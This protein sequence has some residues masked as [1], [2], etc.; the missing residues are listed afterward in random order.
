MLKNKFRIITLLA[1]IILSLM[2]PIVRAENEITDQSD[3]SEEISVISA[4]SS[5]NQD[6]DAKPTTT[7]SNDTMKKQD[8]YLTGDNVTI[9]YIVDGNVFVMADTVNINSQIGGDAFICAKTI[10]IGEQ[11]YVFS[12]LFALAQDVNIKGVVYDL[13]ACSQKVTLDGYI[14]RDIR[15]TTSTLNVNGVV[16]RN[17]YVNCS[18]MNFAQPSSEQQE[19]TAINQ[20][21]INGDLNYTSSKE[22]SIPDGA[23]TGNKNFTEA[24]ADNGNSIQ[25][26]VLSLGTFIATVIIIWLLCLWIAPKFSDNTNNLISNKLLPSLGYGFL[27]PI[28]VSVA[29]IILLMLGITSNIA[30]IS[31]IGLAFLLM[32]SSAIFVIG[33]NNL[34]CQKLKVEKKIGTFGMLILSSALLWLIKLIPYVGSIV[35]LIVSIIGLGMVII[36]IIPARKKSKS[37]NDKTA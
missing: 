28:I 33:I 20:G 17:A 24:K 8:V 25:S 26:Y 23:V 3:H 31:L 30:I 22:L 19:T 6:T 5:E 15:V 16:G 13:Y 21:V 37:E 36:S 27:T 29:I 10:N 12:N 34:I 9:D 14:Y 1:V 2:I 4:D 7:T 32:I 18:D 11:G 35:S